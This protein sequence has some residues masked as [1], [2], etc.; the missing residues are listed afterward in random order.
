MD[1]NRRDQG[2]RRLTISLPMIH[3]TPALELSALALSEEEVT[4]F[5]QTHIVVNSRL[6]PNPAYEPTPCNKGATRFGF[7]D[8][9]YS[10]LH[11]LARY[12]L[13][14]PRSV[15]V[16]DGLLI[17]AGDTTHAIESSL[18]IGNHEEEITV[19]ITTL[20]H[21]TL[22]L[23]IPWMRNHDIRK[24]FAHNTVEPNSEFCIQHC[25]TSL[26][27]VTSMLPTQEIHTIKGL[28]IWATS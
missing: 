1:L 22:V 27:K 23:C 2:Y 17:A 21:D 5:E 3:T 25:L 28:S 14:V 7:I 10:Q 16:I 24:D 6:R 9:E 4:T 13:D 8:A 19:F 12:K 20:K 11:N 26:T 15:D 18:P